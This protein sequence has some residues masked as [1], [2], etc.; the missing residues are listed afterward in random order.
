MKYTYGFA[1]VCSFVVVS[2]VFYWHDACTFALTIALLAMGQLYNDLPAS[3]K[4]PKMSQYQT[5]TKHDKTESCPRFWGFIL[6]WHHSEYDG[7]LNHRRLDCLLN[8]LFRRRSKKT[9]KL[10]VTGLC[11]GNWPGTGEFPSQRASYAEN[12]SVWWR[13][14]I[15][16]IIPWH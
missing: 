5:T 7:V 2:S 11:A 9:S 6:Q 3:V 13:H 4:W 8:C 1:A 14:H 10:R 16:Y 15:L 12:V